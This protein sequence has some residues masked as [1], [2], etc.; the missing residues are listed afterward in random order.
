LF[1]WHSLSDQGPG[2]GALFTLSLAQAGEFGFVL[3]QGFSVKHPMCC[4]I[5]LKP[6]PL[7]W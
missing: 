7:L 5:G 6:K 2:I 4:R 3:V 1:V